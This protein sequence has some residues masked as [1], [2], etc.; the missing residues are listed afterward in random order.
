MTE[1]IKRKIT[2]S[3][4]DFEPVTLNNVMQDSVDREQ[5]TYLKDVWRTFVKQKAAVVSAVVLLIIIFMVI[6]G[7]YMTDYD[8]YSNDYS[9]TNCEP[10]KDHWFG[11]DN[12]G[13][14]LWTRV[15]VGGRVSL[16]IAILATLI[17]ETFGII[18]GSLSGYYGGKLD[19][20]IMR[21]IDIFSGIPELIYMILLMMVFG[22]GNI[23]TL[24]IAISITGWMGTT[25]SARGLVLM[26]KEREYILASKKLGAS[27]WRIILRHLIPNS[28]GYHVV[29]ITM[30]IPSVIFYEAFL[31]FIGLGVTPPN[32][33][34][35][36]LIKLATANFK[37]Y[38]YQFFIP[39]A[40]VCIT[41]LCLNLL[42][43]GLRDALDPKMRE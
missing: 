28:M 2:F 26:L 17:P 18:L 29:G 24:V 20:F 40:V 9:V 16:I 14:D 15:W 22:S 21:I 4:S 42:G 12:L 41:I 19:M 30:T 39:C 35:G 38:P 25:R 43:D 8:Y 27:P 32:P 1:L 6:A 37:E 36:Q 31:S 10:S 33:S 23:I 13:R 11:T 5:T 3:K 7:P 34:W